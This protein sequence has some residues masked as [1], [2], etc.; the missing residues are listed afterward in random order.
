[1]KSR[2][3]TIQ[4]LTHQFSACNEKA[5][6]DWD[7]LVEVGVTHKTGCKLRHTLTRKEGDSFFQSSVQYYYD[8]HVTMLVQVTIK[9]RKKYPALIIMLNLTADSVHHFDW[10]Q[11][12]RKPQLADWRGRGREGYE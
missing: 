5:E 12:D 8:G 1:M 10:I 2:W 6:E 4:G 11:G 7:T 3:A 9:R